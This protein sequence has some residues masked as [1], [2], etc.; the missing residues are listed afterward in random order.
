MKNLFKLTLVLVIGLLLGVLIK[1]DTPFIE[2][3]SEVPVVM[4]TLTLDNQGE[5]DIYLVNNSTYVV[6]SLDDLKYITKKNRK[7]RQVIKDLDSLLSRLPK[8][9]IK[10]IFEKN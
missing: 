9:P 10:P 5:I 4:D 7:V 2:V 3:K 8:T 1:K 6:M